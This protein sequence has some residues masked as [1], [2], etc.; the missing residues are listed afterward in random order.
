MKNVWLNTNEKKTILNNKSK[1]KTLKEW[2]GELVINSS[3][4]EW[5]LCRTCQNII[6]LASL[7]FIRNDS[8]EIGF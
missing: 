6:R 2:R 5:W 8:E 1:K 7:N 4:D 3:E